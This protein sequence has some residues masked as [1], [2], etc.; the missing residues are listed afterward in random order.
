MVPKPFSPLVK[1]EERSVCARPW[2]C[3]A[4]AVLRRGDCDCLARVGVRPPSAVVPAMSPFTKGSGTAVEI[5]EVG[6]SPESSF[7]L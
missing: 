5:T 7:P 1:E 2:V 4:E 3:S 6:A